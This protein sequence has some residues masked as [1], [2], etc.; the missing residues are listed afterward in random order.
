MIA[1]SAA[2]RAPPSVPSCDLRQFYLHLGGAKCKCLSHQYLFSQL[3]TAQAHC[4]FLSDHQKDLNNNIDAAALLISV[5]PVEGSCLSDPRA[6][7]AD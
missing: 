3:C 4:E 2:N 6:P 5:C 1:W 7:F